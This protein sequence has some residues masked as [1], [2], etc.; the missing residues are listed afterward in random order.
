MIT[1]EGKNACLRV[2][3]CGMPQIY[4]WYLAFYNQSQDEF[5]DYPGNRPQWVPQVLMDEVVTGL[6]LII[7]NSY[8]I[9]TEMALMSTD[10]KNNGVDL[11]YG[12][13]TLEN[14]IE[15]NPGQAK[16]IRLPVGWR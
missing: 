2:N 15:F 12:Y 14:P 4:S 8:E 5:T 16:T 10:I 7:P 11:A 13:Y 3:F 1:L 9:I 6:A